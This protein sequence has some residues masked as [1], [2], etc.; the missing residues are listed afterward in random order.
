MTPMAGAAFVVTERDGLVL[1][2]SRG[3]GGWN[4]T[5]PGGGQEPGETLATT[6][7]R[8]LWEE[9]GLIPTTP[10]HFMMGSRNGRRAF[11]YAGGVH[12]RLRGSAE[13][14]A[15]WVPWPFLIERG[16]R[17]RKVFAALSRRAS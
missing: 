9:T 7:A 2:V 12:G 14:D 10:L 16:G 6:A 17:W 15:A 4:W 13:G 5:L 11:F 8:E 3:P 1:A